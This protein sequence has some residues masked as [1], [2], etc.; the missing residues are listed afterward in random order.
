MA[1]EKKGY[2]NGHCIYH[3]RKK[4]GI[5][6]NTHTLSCVCFGISNKTDLTRKCC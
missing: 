3:A 2:L 5:T 4:R 6:S 1:R